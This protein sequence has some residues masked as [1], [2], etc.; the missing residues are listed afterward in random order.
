[1]ETARFL[2]F[3]GFPGFQLELLR[4]Y[5]SLWPLKKSLW[6]LPASDQLKHLIFNMSFEGLPALS[7]H[8]VA[9][10]RQYLSHPPVEQANRGL[11]CFCKA[12]EP[13]LVHILNQQLLILPRA[14]KPFPL[15]TQSRGQSVLILVFLSS[16]GHIL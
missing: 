6:H 14:R 4:V 13:K 12:H 11:I 9:E 5:D 1:M 16:V 3:Y 7:V 15:S 8:A 10:A 2:N